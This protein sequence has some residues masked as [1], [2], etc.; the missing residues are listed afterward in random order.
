MVKILAIA[1]MALAL[2]ACTPLLNPPPAPPSAFTADATYCYRTLA[3][4]DCYARPQ[5]GEEYR[6]FGGYSAAPK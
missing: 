2:A 1:A 5:L 3:R 4:N 6:Y